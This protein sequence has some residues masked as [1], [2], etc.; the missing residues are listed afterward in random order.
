MT[1]IFSL[2]SVQNFI[3]ISTMQKKKI[4]KKYFFLELI[5]SELAALICLY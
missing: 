4:A 2:E 3:Y 1:A 5:A